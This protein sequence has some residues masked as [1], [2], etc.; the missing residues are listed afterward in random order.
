M[1]DH[2]CPIHRFVRP[3][4]S[5]LFSVESAVPQFRKMRTNAQ[6]VV[7]NGENRNRRG[8]A[9]LLVCFLFC[10]NR[11]LLKMKDKMT[12]ILF[13][14]DL[15][16]AL[17]GLNLATAA[18]SMGIEVVIFYTFWG[19]NILRKGKSLTKPKGLKRKLFGIM[20]KG[21]ATK[22][23][24]SRFHMAGIGTEM[25]KQLMKEMK[26]PSIPEL[27]KLAKSL[28]VKFIAC[29]TTMGMMGLTKDDL[30]SEVDAYAGAATYLANASQ[31]KINLFL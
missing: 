7:I 29:T 15:D 11:A 3:V 30:I 6:N 16:K 24:L 4:K 17:A 28:G 23:P 27:M 9:N 31:A 8:R 12:L 1:T 25:M 22:L 13:S 14:G 26:F 5:K 10:P 18:A 2:Y 19:L 20:N 21:G